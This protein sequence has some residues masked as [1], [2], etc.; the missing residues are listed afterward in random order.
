MKKTKKQIEAD[1]IRRLNKN[2]DSK[3]ETLLYKNRILEAR[4]K[5]VTERMYKAEQEAEILKEKAQ[6]YEDWNERLQEYLNMSDTERE[7]LLDK[8]KA[9]KK[10]NQFAGKINSLFSLYSI[11]L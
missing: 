9:E 4:L 10:F 11:M 2:K 3:M 6:K 5:D 1:L 7:C 8:I